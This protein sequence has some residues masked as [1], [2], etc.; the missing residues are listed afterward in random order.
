[1]AAAGLA[2]HSYDH[3]G[4]APPAEGAGMSGR[5]CTTTSPSMTVAAG[6]R[7]AGRWRCTAT[8][9]GA[10]WWPASP[11][12]ARPQPDLVVLS[13][14]RPRFH[15]GRLEKAPGLGAGPIHADPGPAQRRGW[16]RVLAQSVRGREAG[17]GYPLYRRQHLPVRRRRHA[18][19]RASSMARV[20]WACRH[21]CSTARTMAWCRKRRRGC[22][23]ARRVTRRTYPGLRHELH[24]EPEGETIITEVV[25]WLRDTVKGLDVPTHVSLLCRRRR[26]VA[27]ADPARHPPRSRSPAPPG[28]RRTTGSIRRPT[29]TA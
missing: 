29:G 24:N 2:V 3:A 15:A 26:R 11:E 27:H 17:E 5:N 1:M 22:S 4:T 18:G 14:A 20:G 16:R 21:W 28:T 9:S 12:T 10:W 6:L 19:A 8:G 13:L 25:A 23:R 7:E